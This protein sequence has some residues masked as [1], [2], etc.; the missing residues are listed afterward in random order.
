MARDLPPEGAPYEESDIIAAIATLLP[1]IEIV[2]SRYREWTSVGAPSLIADN[3]SNGAWVTGP[4]YTGDW[5]SLD[6]AEHIMELHVNGAAVR[7]GSGEKVMGNPLHALS[8]LVKTLNQQGYGL[9]AD[10]LIS[11]G[12]CCE[13]YN[14]V[15]GDRLHADFGQLGHVE[16]EFR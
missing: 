5:R 6:L 8:W 9:K 16:I 15:P 4:E 12:V 14:A 13:V 7:R 3:G 2:D 10:E 11:T 1:A